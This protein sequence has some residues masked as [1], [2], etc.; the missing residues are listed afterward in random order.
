MERAV[1]VLEHAK[2][3]L[4]K[5]KADEDGHRNK[6]IKHIDTAISEARQIPKAE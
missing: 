2:R 6:A 4:T 3:T 5:A 1:K